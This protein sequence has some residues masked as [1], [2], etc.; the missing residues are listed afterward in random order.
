MGGSAEVEHGE[1]F[2]GMMFAQPDTVPAAFAASRPH[3]QPLM[4]AKYQR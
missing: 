4:P 3:R 1:P 2:I